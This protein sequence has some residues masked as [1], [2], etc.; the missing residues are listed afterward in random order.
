MGRGISGTRLQHPDTSAT[1]TNHSE[2]LL[3][4]LQKKVNGM[5]KSEFVGGVLFR[6]KEKGTRV[7][8]EFRFSF[9]RGKV[10]G[11]T[12]RAVDFSFPGRLK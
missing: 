10:K 11:N 9:F 6:K 12:P 5:H 8:S 3:C 1:L 4:F 7:I 2:F